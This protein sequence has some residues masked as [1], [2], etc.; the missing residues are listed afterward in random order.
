MHQHRPRKRF[1]QNF[2]RDDGVI[3]GIER[4]IAP[5]ADDHLV[6]IGPGEG[7]LTQALVTSG[8]KLD[9]VELDR[10]LTLAGR[11]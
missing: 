9:A 4:A 3:H 10:N 6:E 8:C 5:T 11:V 1:G 7:A 2:L